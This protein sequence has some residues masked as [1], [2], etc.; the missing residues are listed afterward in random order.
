VKP[1][2]WTKYQ[3]HRKKDQRD[4]N[5]DEATWLQKGNHAMKVS[6]KQ[7][8]GHSTKSLQQHKRHPKHDFSIAIK[9]DLYNHVI[10]LPSSFDYQNEKLVYDSL[11]NLR[12]ENEPNKSG[13]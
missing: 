13:K 9:H 2:Q 10:V 4:P 1:V 11:S 3:R 7:I 8:E 6:Y 5:R 12:N